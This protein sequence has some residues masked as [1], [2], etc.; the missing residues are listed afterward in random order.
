MKWFLGGLGVLVLAFA[1]WY[2]V[3]PAFNA[4]EV[5]DALPVMEFGG[6]ETDA[7]RVVE[8]VVDNVSDGELGEIDADMVLEGSAPSPAAPAPQAE[9]A[10]RGP[11]PVV[12]TPTHPASGSVFVFESETGTIIR[13]ENFETINGPSLHVYLAKDIDATEYVDLGP[14]RGTRGNINYKVPEGV[15]LSE[16]PIVMY[17]CV[18]FRVL[19]NYAEIR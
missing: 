6:A 19:F 1:G 17:W 12:D 9:P 4:V 10:V 18:P 11:F 14:I 5:D 15:D 13:Y 2:F 16:Y 3:L 8:E 7:G